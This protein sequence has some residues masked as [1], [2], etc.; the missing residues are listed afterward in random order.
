MKCIMRGDEI[1]RVKDETAEDR[2]KN[3]WKYCPKE[4]WKELV[5]GTKITKG[6]KSEDI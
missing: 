3:G 4:L 6:K 1:K 5:R 2:V